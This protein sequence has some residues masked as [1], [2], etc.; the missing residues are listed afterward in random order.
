MIKGIFSTFYFI[1]F[2]FQTSFIQK[3]FKIYYPV[4]P[5]DK[6]LC[7]LISV[8][9]ITLYADYVISFCSIRTAQCRSILELT[10]TFHHQ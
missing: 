2:F 7:K 6:H 10:S 5:R 9:A 4:T 8:P 1:S 3:R